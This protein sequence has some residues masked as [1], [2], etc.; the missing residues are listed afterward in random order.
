VNKGSCLDLTRQNCTSL[1]D[2][3][4]GIRAAVRR[5]DRLFPLL[6]DLKPLRLVAVGPDEH[7]GGVALLRK[8]PD[9]DLS[10]TCAVGLH[11]MKARGIGRCW[12]TESHLS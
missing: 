3:C 2:N 6:E 5:G 7:A 8:F 10:L 12:S 1:R 4:P 11:L 9:Q